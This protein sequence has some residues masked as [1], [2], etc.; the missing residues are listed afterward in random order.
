VRYEATTRFVRGAA[1][2]RDTV[3]TLVMVT[4]GSGAP[5]DVEVPRDCPVIVYAYRSAALRDS[6]PL[7]AEPAWRSR[8]P[9]QL[10]QHR[11]TL[12]PGASWV[13]QHDV[14]AAEL[15]ASA[16]AGRLWF[17]AWVAGSHNA[18]LAAGD[19]ELR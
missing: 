2:A 10:V 19:V 9:C 3:R 6:V 14:A 7:L 5:R 17:T 13:F 1:P 4:N 12:A 16:G 11:F 15:R 18:L 8:Q